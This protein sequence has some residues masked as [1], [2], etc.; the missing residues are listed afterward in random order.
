[1]KKH[2]QRKMKLADV[3]NAVAQYARNDHEVG[4][5]VSDLI[6]RGLVRIHTHN[7]RRRSDK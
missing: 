2:N 3:I 7:R 1:M 4:I 6:N 5:V